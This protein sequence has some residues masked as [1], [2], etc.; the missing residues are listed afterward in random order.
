MI[1]YLNSI[2]YRWNNWQGTKFGRLAATAK[3]KYRTRQGRIQDFLKGGSDTQSCTKRTQKI[4][5]PHPFFIKTTPIF[6]R[7]IETAS[8]IDLFLIDYLLKHTKVSHSSSFLSS[9]A[10][11][12]GSILWG[13]VCVKIKF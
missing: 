3:L 6:N 11:E 12:G 4:L 2:L 10:R 9:V 7:L 1:I 13:A 8:P 5:K